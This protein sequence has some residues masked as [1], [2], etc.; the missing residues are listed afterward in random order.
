[1]TARNAN[2]TSTPMA[3]ASCVPLRCNR[4]GPLLLLIE[5]IVGYSVSIHIV[6]FVDSCFSRQHAFTLYVLNFLKLSHE[7]VQF[8]LVL[9]DMDNPANFLEN[10]ASLK[11]AHLKTRQ[12]C[13]CSN[14]LIV[15]TNEWQKPV[16]T[17]IILSQF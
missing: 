5:F 3:Q 15:Q 7:L 17:K 1:M 10:R 16:A 11:G 4:I 14:W 6:Y 2:V 9:I 8:C 12:V 13:R